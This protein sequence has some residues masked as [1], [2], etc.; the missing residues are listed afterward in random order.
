MTDVNEVVLTSSAQEAVLYA[1]TASYLLEKL[2]RDSA[3]Q[4]LQ[5]DERPDD[6]LELLKEAGP[7]RDAL[8][9]VRKYL[10]LVA[11]ATSDWS[12]RWKALSEIDLSDLEWAEAI[13]GLVRAENIPTTTFDVIAGDQPAI[14]QRFNWNIRDFA[15]K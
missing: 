13:L 10:L 11:V 3:V 9:V 7:A 6:L 1:N 8:D 4:M 15:G 5:N 12:E 14:A 2:R